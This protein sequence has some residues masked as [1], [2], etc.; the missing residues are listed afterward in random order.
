[1]AQSPL[2]AERRKRLDRNAAAHIKAQVTGDGAAASGAAHALPDP[3]AARLA[4]AAGPA[5]AALL[6]ASQPAPQSTRQSAGYASAQID[7]PHTEPARSVMAQASYSQAVT[8]R[9]ASAPTG[10]GAAGQKTPSS[11]QQAGGVIGNWHNLREIPVD[12]AALERNLVITAA[13]KEPVHAAFDVLRTKIMQAMSAK[14]WR[15]VAITSPTKGCGKSFTAINLAVALSRYPQQRTVLLDMDLRQPALASRLGISGAGAIGD[16]LR[17]QTS[18]AEHLV[19]FGPNAFNMGGNVALGLNERVEAYPSELF[20]D[21][22]TTQAL[23]RIEADFAPDIMLFD[24]PPALVHDDAIAL[25]Q[26]VDCV[27]MVVGAGITTPKSLREAVRRLGD[28]KPVLGV[29]LNKA[30]Q[31]DLSSYDY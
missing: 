8:T 13:R 6:P 19:R 23:A 7:P 14:G 27:L 24:M 5:P 29:V 11:P 4:A 1:M 15:R 30:D 28:E 18:P 16:M 21:S 25:R 17:G 10:S 22:S 26:H 12:S 20:L 9:A 3:E 2:P 31:I